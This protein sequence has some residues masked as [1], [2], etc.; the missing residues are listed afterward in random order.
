MDWFI[1]VN[2]KKQTITLK[3]AV[4]PSIHFSLKVADI[5]LKSK[6]TNKIT[7]MIKISLILSINNMSMI[8]LSRR[9]KLS[10]YFDSKLN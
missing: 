4:S 2:E 8:I 1:L 3:W 5:H 9:K 6:N 7:G 10:F